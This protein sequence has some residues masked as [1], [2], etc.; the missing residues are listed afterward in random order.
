MPP[1]VC[2]FLMSNRLVDLQGMEES[3]RGD[4]KFISSDIV[5]RFESASH[6][7]CSMHVRLAKL[8]ER[9]LSFSFRHHET[10]QLSFERSPSGDLCLQNN[11]W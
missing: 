2:L 6:L 11:E 7:P 1:A 3:Q 8:G 5:S 9:F 10:K 4:P